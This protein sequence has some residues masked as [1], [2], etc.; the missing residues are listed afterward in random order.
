MV[1][2]P[3]SDGEAAKTF[4]DDF[5]SGELDRSKWNVNPTGHVVNDEHDWTWRRDQQIVHD[6]D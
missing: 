2:V 1:S 5:S 6:A 3:E 4:F